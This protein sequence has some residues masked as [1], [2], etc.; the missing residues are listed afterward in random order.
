MLRRALRGLQK[1]GRRAARRGNAEL[2]IAI[3]LEPEE[4][5]GSE[6][7]NDDGTQQGPPMDDDDNEDEEM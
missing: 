3:G 4:D 6:V 1:D 7:E 2:R 5:Y